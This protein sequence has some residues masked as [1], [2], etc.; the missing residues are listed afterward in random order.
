[1]ATEKPIIFDVETL[2]ALGARLYGHG[3]SI[4]NIARQDM[5][6]DLRLATRAIDKLTTLRLRISEIA[7]SCMIQAPPATRRDALDALA[8]AN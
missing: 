3:E 8:A 7:E 6:D 5:A 2:N 1:M 4:T